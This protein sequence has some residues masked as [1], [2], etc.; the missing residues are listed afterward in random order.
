MKLYSAGMLVC[1]LGVGAALSG[2][3]TLDEVFRQMD[4]SAP[5]FRA[6]AGQIQRTS[7]TKVI[8]DTTKETGSITMRKPK[9]TEIRALIRFTEPDEKT[10][11]LQ[12]TKA[13]IYFPKLKTVQVY[14]LGK[15]KQLVDQF[16]LLGFGTSGKELAKSYD[17]KATGEET[18]AGQKATRLEMVPKSAEARKHLAKIE[19]WMSNTGAYPIQQKL[20]QPSGDYNLI[21]YTDVKMNP[22]LADDSVQLKV[23]GGVKRE[24]PQK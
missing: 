1:V 4:A 23:P 3:A 9:P 18:I 6:M 17:V 7:Y 13:E 12:G 15:Q 8:D 2:A 10:V 16:V 24:Y 19:L 22:N 5:G 14:D 20:Y 21:T 11:S